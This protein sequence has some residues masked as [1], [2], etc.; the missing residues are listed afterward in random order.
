M[1]VTHEGI[2]SESTTC[3][4]VSEKC[5]R[6]LG[7][8]LSETG[9]RKRWWI[10][11]FAALVDTTASKQILRSSRIDRESSELSYRPSLPHIPRVRP[12]LPPPAVFHRLWR[13][14]GS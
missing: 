5:P 3:S 11:S 1:F 4:V 8:W 2:F 9:G 12:K 14:A 6:H 10:P 7:F 13:A